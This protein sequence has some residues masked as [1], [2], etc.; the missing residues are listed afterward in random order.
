MTPSS[1][2]VASMFD[3]AMTRLIAA[4]RNFG[5][6]FQRASGVFREGYV[7]MRVLLF[8]QD[9]PNTGVDRTEDTPESNHRASNR[10]N[11][12]FHTD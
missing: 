5:L 2:P 8:T 7:R 12:P 4:L 6:S 3:R 1:S 9:L 11:S 10:R